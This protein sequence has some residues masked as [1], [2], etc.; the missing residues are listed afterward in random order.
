[1]KKLILLLS[2]IILLFQ[3][4]GVSQ[5]DKNVLVESQGKFY[6]QNKVY[7]KSELGKLFSLDDT[8]FKFYKK[9]KRAKNVF[10]ASGITTLALAGGGL[11]LLNLDGPPNQS[12]GDRCYEFC[13]HQRVG[14]VMFL[15]SLPPA[16]ATIISMPI[17][18]K[19]YKRTKKSFHIYTETAPKIGANQK[20][21]DLNYTGNGIG[22]VLN[23]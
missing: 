9:H 19:N 22:M 2:F 4:N 3:Q 13:P 15:A 17:S 20:E 21:L 7:K 6:Y 10:I 23:F 11:I 12:E 18:R 5:I 1:M 14:L 8:T 16:L